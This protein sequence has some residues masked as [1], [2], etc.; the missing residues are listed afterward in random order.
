MLLVG[1]A[2][3]GN[4]YYTNNKII[5]S[6]IFDVVNDF[7]LSES[8]RSCTTVLIL[9]SCCH[10]VGVLTTRGAHAAAS[11]RGVTRKVKLAVGSS[12][13]FFYNMYINM[14]SPA[15]FTGQS[16]NVSWRT[17]VRV[18]S[19]RYRLVLVVSVV[20]LRK[21]KDAIDSKK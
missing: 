10:A 15:L 7:D 4:E 17:R 14:C 9:T 16:V 1:R 21:R 5:I 18:C 3:H 8:A 6:N 12:C 19:N 11:I 2:Y 13:C 20:V